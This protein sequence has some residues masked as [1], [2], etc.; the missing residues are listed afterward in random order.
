MK[1]LLVLISLVIPLIGCVSKPTKPVDWS[2]VAR[3]Y[4][5]TYPTTCPI[6]IK[7]ISPPI[8]L[9]DPD[10]D[11]LYQAPWHRYSCPTSVT[12][13]LT[14]L[15]SY[16][17]CTKE[18]VINLYTDLSNQAIA[19]I[20]CYIDAEK[21]RL[22][23]TACKTIDTDSIKFIQKYSHSGIDFNFGLPICVTSKEVLQAS[24]DSMFFVSECKTNV[25]AFLGKGRAYSFMQQKSSAEIVNSF[26]INM[27]R[28]IENDIDWVNKRWQCKIK[29]ANPC[30]VGAYPSF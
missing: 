16:F 12:N 28:D 22:D 29:A 19:V 24:R 5:Q 2:V 8:C 21:Q 25:E 27:K 15:E 26:V 9:T 10:S 6:Q 1:R 20:N 17:E 11:S 7:S 23:I 13:Y 14:H 3:N 4:V 30:Y 18:E